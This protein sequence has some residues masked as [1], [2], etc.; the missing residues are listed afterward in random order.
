MI[1]HTTEGFKKMFKII[2]TTITTEIINMNMK[3]GM[4]TIDKIEAETEGEENI[5]TTIIIQTIKI[6]EETTAI[7]ITIE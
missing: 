1:F 6:I 2:T 7:T 5:E 3:I 4:T